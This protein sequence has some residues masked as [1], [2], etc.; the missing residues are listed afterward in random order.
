MEA[1][2]KLQRKKRIA[3]SHMSKSNLDGPKLAL[4]DIVYKIMNDM[5]SN[6]IMSY[7]L[8]QDSKSRRRQETSKINGKCK[9][10]NPDSYCKK[11]ERKFLPKRSFP[12]MQKCQTSL[13]Y[14]NKNRCMPK[15]RAH[16]GLIPKPPKQPAAFPGPSISNSMTKNITNSVKRTK[17]QSRAY[18][19]VIESNINRD[20]NISQG[21]YIQQN[22]TTEKEEM[23]TQ[24]NDSSNS[25]DNDAAYENFVKKNKEDKISSDIDSE[26]HLTILRR[27]SKST[28]KRQFKRQSTKCIS[29]VTSI[30]LSYSSDSQSEEALEANERV[31][32]RKV[33]T[34]IRKQV[35]AKTVESL[36]SDSSLDELPDLNTNYSSSEEDTCVGSAATENTE[37]TVDFIDKF[38]PAIENSTDKV[39]TL[40]SSSKAAHQQGDQNLASIPID[41]MNQVPCCVRLKR[42]PIIE[43]KAE[44]YISSLNYSAVDCININDES[45]TESSTLLSNDSPSF[46]SNSQHRGTSVQSFNSSNFE[47][48]DDCI[49]MCELPKVGASASHEQPPSRRGVTSTSP[50]INCE[51][52]SNSNEP[53]NVTPV[54]GE[55]TSRTTEE[56]KVQ[57]VAVQ[58]VIEQREN[59]LMV[60]AEEENDIEI[61]DLSDDEV[62]SQQ[63][64]GASKECEVVRQLDAETNT[65]ESLQH[66]IDD[67]P[68]IPDYQN[69][70]SQMLLSNPINQGRCQESPVQVQKFSNSKILDMLNKIDFN[71][72]KEILSKT[73]SNKSEASVAGKTLMSNKEQ[74]TSNSGP[75]PDSTNKIF[76]KPNAAIQ[77]INSS[78]TSACVVSSDPA[79]ELR[80][81]NAFKHIPV[82]S[83]GETNKLNA[84]LSNKIYAG[85]DNAPAT[86]NCESNPIDIPVTQKQSVTVCD[87]F[88]NSNIKTLIQK[89]IMDSEMEDIGENKR[90]S[91]TINVKKRKDTAIYNPVIKK[92]KYEMFENSSDELDVIA[93]SFTEDLGAPN[94]KVDALLN[95]YKA[96]YA[97]YMN[98][99]NT[100]AN[101][102][103]GLRLLHDKQLEKLAHLRSSIKNVVK[104]DPCYLTAVQEKF[105]SKAQASIKSEEKLKPN[106][107][108]LPGS[109]ENN[110]I[111]VHF[112]T[113][114]DVI[115][116]K[117]SGSKIPICY[118]KLEGKLI[119][120][121]LDQSEAKVKHSVMTP[122]RERLLEYL[123]NLKCDECGK[124]AAVSCQGCAHA[125]YCSPQ[126]ALLSWKK[127]HKIACRR[128]MQVENAV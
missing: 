41:S 21:P 90:L 87:N 32:H 120:S 107:L 33:S 30:P 15:P 73:N 85:E 71:S 39:S 103:Q 117:P 18:S 13:K 63:N 89:Q 27:K 52:S 47:E 8:S 20:S 53:V 56:F 72:I 14:L 3:H 48:M 82:V 113:N 114:I 61:I 110:D 125:F 96:E 38:M 128:G 65:T 77:G 17:V 70:G 69:R 55:S 80:S 79:I 50:E 105:E 126:C 49:I 74:H 111:P 44:T 59:S 23:K 29:K 99:V 81:P 118:P 83:S 68:F 97:K 25:D 121:A 119:R 35:P 10:S 95:L 2:S 102:T 37:P 9:N 86:L 28:Q 31:K 93:A 112:K 127:G 43:Q 101:V 123:R 124:P 109:S 64:D 6:N 100:E 122:D 62:I 66:D 40:K 1:N 78:I 115:D 24:N 22:E 58:S 106:S 88:H 16:V 11:L 42:D 5:D 67:I 54:S 7:E 91:L 98:I 75:L 12:L 34:K 4:D 76:S 36:Q 84:E 60:K 57:I 45:D 51:R 92:P 116:A 104:H 46:S 26:S 19:K 108:I 94:K